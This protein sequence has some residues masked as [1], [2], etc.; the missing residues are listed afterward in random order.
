MD[1]KIY[2][3]IIELLNR[4]NELQQLINA[5]KKQD[6]AFLVVNDKSFELT[7]TQIKNIRK[8]LKKELELVQYHIR[9]CE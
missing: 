8:T 4:Y 3:E 1:K 9:N 5:L 2:N 6:K 7:A